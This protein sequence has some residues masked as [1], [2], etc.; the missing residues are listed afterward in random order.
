M[1][2]AAKRSG[3]KDLPDMIL[4]ANAFTAEEH[5]M[6]EQKLRSSFYDKSGSSFEEILP[7]LPEILAE[8]Q[9]QPPVLGEPQV[10]RV[11]SD[12][13]AKANPQTPKRKAK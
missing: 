9:G 8:L 3:I 13:P 6:F 12:S 4:K 7:F 2:D 11:A 1:M 10:P 5:R